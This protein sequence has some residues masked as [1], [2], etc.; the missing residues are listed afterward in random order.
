[1]Q[2][3][4]H[5][6][7]GS[8]ASGEATFISRGQIVQK[9]LPYQHLIPRH[10][11]MHAENTFLQIESNT[12]ASL[13]AGITKLSLEDAPA[14]LFEVS[15]SLNLTSPPSNALFAATAK[16][17]HQLK[18][19][20]AHP[21]IS[22]ESTRPG[23]NQRKGPPAVPPLGLEAE[24][25]FPSASAPLKAV[26]SPHAPMQSSSGSPRHL[27]IPTVQSWSRSPPPLWPHQTRLS[28][29]SLPAAPLPNHFA[30]GAAA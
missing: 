30:S 18:L 23:S 24:A 16:S 26:P 2:E 11:I 3:A 20:H 6:P 28:L 25:D 7:C 5:S 29:T 9:P 13:D 12:Q 22:P 15:P 4:N 17:A 19:E 1:V 27:P 8:G 21:E 10:A 14:L